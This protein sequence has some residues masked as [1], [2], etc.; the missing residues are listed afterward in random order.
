MK[1]RLTIAIVLLLATSSANA[2]DNIIKLKKLRAEVDEITSQFD[3]LK[4]NVHEA[5]F[6]IEGLERDVARFKKEADKSRE[7]TVALMDQINHMLL[8]R[9]AKTTTYE[10]LANIEQLYIDVT[11]KQKQIY[12]FERYA[13]DEDHCE[14][15]AG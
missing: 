9:K 5:E 10:M 7:R 2:C 14:I 12:V 13:F 15:G 8:L 6:I 3:R 4:W 11:E 1:K